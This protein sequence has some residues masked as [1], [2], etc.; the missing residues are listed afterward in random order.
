MVVISKSKENWMQ[1]NSI[2]RKQK[3]SEKKGNSVIVQQI[4]NTE[5]DSYLW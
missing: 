1:I 4:L 2:N 5:V 3:E